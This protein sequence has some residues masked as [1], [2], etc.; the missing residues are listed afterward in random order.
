MN[1]LN[2]NSDININNIK[3]KFNKNLLQFRNKKLSK[4]KNKNLVISTFLKRKTM[5]KRRIL[6]FNVKKTSNCL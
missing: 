1:K 4:W 3:V 5:K 2:V 6:I